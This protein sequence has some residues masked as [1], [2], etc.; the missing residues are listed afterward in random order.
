MSSLSIHLPD[1]LHKR[2]EELAAR[3]ELSID[4][5]IATAIAEKMAVLMTSVN[6][7]ARAVRGS[8]ATFDR[9]LA[10]V[11]DVEPLPHDR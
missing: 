10:N 6:L 4:Q 8:R 5:F 11:P 9:A 1:A 7:E 2:M 3:E